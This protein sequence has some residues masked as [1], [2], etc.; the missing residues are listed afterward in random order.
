M[1][2]I[3]LTGVVTNQPIVLDGVTGSQQ[4][5]ATGVVS[6]RGE[7]GA[8]GATGPAGTNGIDGADGQK[9]FFAVVGTSE[10]DYIVDG[11]ADDVQIQAALDAANAA[12]GGTV[13]LKRGAYNIST[14]MTISSSTKVVG[15]G[16]QA[17]LLQTTATSGA[18]PGGAIF[19]TGSSSDYITVSDMEILGQGETYTSGYGIYMPTGVHSF[20]TIERVYAHGFPNCGIYVKDPILSSFEDLWVRDNGQDGLFIEIGTSCKIKTVYASGNNRSGIHLKTNTYSTI[21]NCASE[22]NTFAYWLES[23]G[24]I[25][26]NAPGAEVAIRADGGTAGLV[27][28]YR[29]QSSQNIVMNTPYSS[30]FAYLSGVPAYHMYI[31]GS[32]RI[33]INAPRGFAD[34]LTSG[35]PHEAPT[36]TLYIDSNSTVTVTDQSYTG[37]IGGGVSGNITSEQTST[38]QTYTSLSN[39]NFNLSRNATTNSA[40]MVYRTNTNDVW[41]QGLRNDST[42]NYHI[43]DAVNSLSALKLVPN[44]E[45]VFNDDGASVDFRVEGD[46]D[47]NLLTVDGSADRVGIGNATPAEKL[48]VL[49]NIKASGSVGTTKINDISGNE[50]IIITPTASAVNE[51]TIVNAATGTNPQLTTSGG[52]TNVGIDATTKGNGNYNFYTGSLAR[53]VFRLAN[54]ASSVNYI[55]ISPSATGTALPI[56]A[57]GSDTDIGINLLP[58]GAGRL[59]AGGV[60]IQTISSTDTITNKRFTKRVLPLSANSATPAINTNTYD[61]VNITAQ[62]AAITS[63]TTNLSGTPVDGDTLRISV[64]GTGSVALTFGSSFEAS[65]VALP[66]TTSSTIRLDMGF[67]W[68]TATS[69]WRCVAVA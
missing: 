33:Q 27:T 24:N 29:I 65:T 56:A 44:T 48:D 7:D 38:S 3:V 32:S 15:D 47:T 1:N 67:F 60:N 9:P 11:V 40:L 13:Y 20:I 23:C 42:S 61:V 54:V 28:H 52:D 31:T 25:S 19:Q 49:G 36:N 18:L 14:A 50:G 43:R 58:K 22:Y 53:Q 39:V 59:Q 57:Q 68:N 34:T 51:F 16:I 17:T 37:S 21:D 12:G 63:F 6:I 69:K 66:T 8:Q 26:L 4:V 35:D 62:T 5:V 55:Q 46:T 2:S 64:T 45:Y 30:Q 41:S 10:A